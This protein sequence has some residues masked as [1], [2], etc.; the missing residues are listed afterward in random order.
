MHFFEFTTSIIMML[1][2]SLFEDSCH[3][4]ICKCVVR[5]INPFR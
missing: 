3:L 1:K 4:D 5:R 2:L